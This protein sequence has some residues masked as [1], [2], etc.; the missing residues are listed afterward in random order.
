[1]A[2]SIWNPGST[3]N[4]TL[5]SVAPVQFVKGTA[6][7]PGITFVG[8]TDTGI[9]SESEGYI[10]F[11]VNGVN[12]LKITPSG[13]VVFGG[14]FASADPV[15]I[16][17]AATIDAGGADSNNLI[18]TGN[19]GI[20]SLGTTYYGPV[21]ARFTGTPLLMHS[22]QLM[23][24]GASNK[25]VVVDDCAVF[26]PKSTA[27]VLDGWI[28]IAYLNTSSGTSSAE[29]ATGAAGNYAFYENDMTI[30]GD[31]TLRNGKNAMSAGP[32]TIETGVTVTVP[33]GATWTIV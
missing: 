33:T 23:L 17:S 7:A 25:S 11:T 6:S 1:M 27:G 31:Y 18:I 20:S 14:K 9:W 10:N 32:M 13:D 16:A 12:K 21:F 19:N 26:M 28:C 15:T 29:G 5:P 4:P 24:P 8:D 30:T 3:T 2:A 22:A